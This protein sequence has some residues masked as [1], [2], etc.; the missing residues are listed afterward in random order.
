VRKVDAVTLLQLAVVAVVAMVGLVAL[1]LV[2]IHFGRTPLPEGRGRR[3]FLLGFLIL[4]PLALGAL[5]TE[6]VAAVPL[7]AV[8]GLPAY[9][10]ITAGLVIL[11]S[12]VAM[13]LGQVTHGRSGR[14]VRLGLV[15]NAGDPHDMPRNPPMTAP[16]AESIAVVDQANARF[17]RGPEFSTQI[18][19]SGFRDDWKAL[20]QATRTLEGQIAEDRRLSLGVAEVA[21]VTA[22]DARTR[23]DTLRG[24]ATADGAAW[25]AT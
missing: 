21:T 14:M 18:G 3:L 19:R 4:P 24:L 20:D 25:P 23:L 8:G 5:T 13:F 10:A 15:G 12:A 17:P 6:G 16:L 1:R 7:R 2:R 9:V 22:W 11:M